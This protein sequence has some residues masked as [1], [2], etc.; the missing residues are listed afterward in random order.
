MRKLVF[1]IVGLGSVAFLVCTTG[2]AQAAYPC[3]EGFTLQSGFCKPYR[4]PHTGYGAY[5]GY[6][7]YGYSYPYRRHYRHRYYYG[8]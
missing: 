6:R 1:A 8:Y 5:R 2:G 7:A 4:G 3:G